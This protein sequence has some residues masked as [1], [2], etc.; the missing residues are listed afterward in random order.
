MKPT[1]FSR[2]GH[3]LSQIQP[4]VLAVTAA[5]ALLASYMTLQKPLARLL[6]AR[7]PLYGLSIAVLEETNEQAIPNHEVWIEEMQVDT[8]T[9][10]QELFAGSAASGF[11]FRKAE[12]YGY[13]GDVIVC[14]EGVGSEISFS[15]PVGKPFSCKF[16]KQN[17]SGIV[18]VTLEVGGE[19]VQEE[20]IDLFADEAGQYA[21]YTVPESTEHVPG[22]LTAVYFGSIALL[23]ALLFV[24][25]TA[26]LVKLVTPGEDTQ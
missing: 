17:L 25:C 10:L 11:E 6:E 18:H 7:L 16:W 26:A 2:Y 23:G 21:T 13:S 24:I 5:L 15:W 20:D 19:P 12:D 8:C 3:G 22:Y 14:T 1:V 4:L 9:D